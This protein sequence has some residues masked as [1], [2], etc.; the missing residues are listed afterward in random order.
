MQHLQ[1]GS[2]AVSKQTIRP[3]N[4]CAEDAFQTG[5]TMVSEPVQPSQPFLG[6]RALMKKGKLGTNNTDNHKHYFNIS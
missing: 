6:I 4:M 3:V 2:V 5:W 1:I